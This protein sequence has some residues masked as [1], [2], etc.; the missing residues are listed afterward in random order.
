MRVRNN[1]LINFILETSQ[2]ILVFLGVYAALMCFCTSL[3]LTLDRWIFLIVIFAAAVLFYGLFTVLE[4]FRHGK[5]YGI[6]GITLFYALLIFRFRGVLKKGVITIANDFL[7]EFMNYTKSN[8]D[9]LAFTDTE[10]ASVRFC[11]TLVVA[12]VGVYLITII[13]AFFYRRRRSLVFVACTAPFAAVPLLVGRLGYFSNLFTYLIV[14]MTIIGTRHM[15]TDATDRRMRQK[16]SVILVVIGLVIG[17]VSYVY[18]PPQRYEGGK[19]KINQVR[20][21]VMAL[22]AWSGDDVATW[23]QSYFSGDA[24]DYGKIGKKNEITYNGRTILKVSGDVNVN[25]G[26]YL[27]GYVGDVYEKNRWSSLNRNSQYREELAA[28]DKEGLAPDKWHVRL[29][30]DLVNRFGS[31]D[32]LRTGKLRI[33]NLGFGYGNYLVPYEPAGSF[34]EEDSGRT[35]IDVLGI[36][37]VV[38]YYTRYPYVLTG[39]FWKQDF[40]LG[41]VMFWESN[42]AERETMSNFVHKYYLQVPDSLSGVCDEFKEYLEENG[43]LLDKY[44]N[45]TAGEADMVRAAREYV[46]ADTSYSLAPGRTPSGQDTVEY[47]LKEGKKGYCTYYATATAMLLRSAGVPARYVEGVYIGQEELEKAAAEGTEIDVPDRAAH[48][49]IEVYTDQ[50]GFVPVEVTPG[51]GEQDEYSQTSDKTSDK[52]DQ[53]DSDRPSDKNEE[54]VIFDDIE[55]NEDEPEQSEEAGGQSQSQK[56]MLLLIL[57]I[58]GAVLAVILALEIQRRVRRRIFIRKQK[59]MKPRKRIRA[60]Y[61]HLTP[62]LAGKGVRYRQQSISEYQLEMAEAMEMSMAEL[63]EFV[64]LLFHARF[65][66]DDITESQMVSFWQTYEAVRARAWKSAKLF[67]KIYYMYIMVL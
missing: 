14:A 17:A 40:S 36:D 9:L 21:S 51:A 29:R 48:A 6:L 67:R 16:L 13:S 23:V 35:T 44:Q 2:I 15:R 20:N 24:I 52:T 60:I 25:H 3:E 38:E 10:T 46:M 58:L 12:L 66:P 30:N 5:V 8:L 18:M 59:G 50:Y 55:G 43:N 42:R 61:H 56:K 27:K 53:T 47:F 34:K 41:N 28:L 31:D 33:R 32:L 39:D 19:R 62:M 4:T 49:W 64:E 1:K 26:L 63:E 22:S 37:Y 65:G 11:T 7:K 54:S 45:G 57:E